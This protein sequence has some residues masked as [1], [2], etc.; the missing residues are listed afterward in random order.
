MKR[1]YVVLVM[2]I[3]SSI[4][5]I[6][7]ESSAIGL[8]IGVG[9]WWQSPSGKLAYNGDILTGTT[10]DLKDDLNYSQEERPFARIKVDLPS[11]IPNIYF[12]ATPMEFSGTGQVSGGFDFGDISFTG[13][14]FDS[15]LKWDHYDVALYYGIPLLKSASLKKLNIDIGLDARIIDAKIDIEQTTSGV[16]E[17]VSETIFLPMIYGGIQFRPVKFLSFEGEGFVTAFSGDSYVDLIGRVKIKPIGPIYIAG[18]YR[19][20]KIDVDRS[21]IVVDVEFSGPFVEA[22][23]EF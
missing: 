16:Q 9:Y 23:L 2:I 3:L 19:S 18:G 7:N 4:L 21:D 13:A 11:F 22:G 20:E 8:E 10:L 17:S 5:L 15:K 14:P 1:L 12:M 6:P